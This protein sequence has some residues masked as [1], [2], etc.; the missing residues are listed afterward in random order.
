VMQNSQV[1][2]FTIGDRR[3]DVDSYFVSPVV[4]GYTRGSHV[5]AAEVY[6]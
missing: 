2:S 4:V 5:L 3:P 1:P 6:L